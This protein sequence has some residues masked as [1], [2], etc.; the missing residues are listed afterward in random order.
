[1]IEA[2]LNDTSTVGI[3]NNLFPLVLN[4]GRDLDTDTVSGWKFLSFGE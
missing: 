4:P 2:G 1:M 3:R